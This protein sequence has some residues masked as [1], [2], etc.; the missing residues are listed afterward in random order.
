MLMSVI[1]PSGIMQL[2]QVEFLENNIVSNWRFWDKIS[3]NGSVFFMLDK[4][5]QFQSCSEFVLFTTLFITCFCINS[6]CPF[7]I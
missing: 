2:N 5:L 4:K 7:Q 6:S 1:L 3:H